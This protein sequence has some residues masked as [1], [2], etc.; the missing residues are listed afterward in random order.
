MPAVKTNDDVRGRWA[1][2]PVK[3]F[4]W[5]KSRL[6]GV[7]SLTVR[8]ELARSLMRGVVNALLESACFERVLVELL[9]D[10]LHVEEVGVLADQGVVRFD[11]DLD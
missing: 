2:V 9:V 11:Q 3:S 1:V 5:A 10:V 7:L 6:E 8:R 4:D